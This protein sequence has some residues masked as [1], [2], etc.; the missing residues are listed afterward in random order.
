M[1]G[2]G[3]GAPDA[4]ARANSPAA[5]GTVAGTA[6][7]PNR[8]PQRPSPAPGPRVSAPRM[9]E[10]II[11][12]AD[13]IRD[14]PDTDERT[15]RL[16]SF[17]AVKARRETASQYAWEGAF[18]GD[19]AATSSTVLEMRTSVGTVAVVNFADGSSIQ[20]VPLGDGTTRVFRSKDQLPECG[21]LR[22]HGA[23]RPGCGWYEPNL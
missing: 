5:A 3:A 21:G 6:N 12:T 16:G 13:L 17:G 14:D 18:T 8:A 7:T 23:V 20:A 22:H 11:T 9:D 19:D 2:G 4:A 10:V 15:F 1:S